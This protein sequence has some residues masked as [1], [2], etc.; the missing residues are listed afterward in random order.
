MAGLL[1]IAPLVEEVDIRGTKIDVGGISASGV[2]DL[3]SRF[4]ELQNLKELAT[5]RLISMG[6]EVVQ[7]V[8]AA[9]CGKPGDEAQ[10]AAAGNLSLGDQAELL[11]AILRISLPNGLAPILRLGAILNGDAAAQKV[12]VTKSRPQ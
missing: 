12:R 8:I 7:A 9:G 11:N 3:L 1:D 5:D 2:A 4:P 10:E 6:G